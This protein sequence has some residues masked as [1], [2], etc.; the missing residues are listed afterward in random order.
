[1]RTLW[2]P[3]WPG[4]AALVVRCLA[5]ALLPLWALGCATEAPV[6][7]SLERE[8]AALRQGFAPVGARRQRPE[9]AAA[10]EG[11]LDSFLRYASR[12]N[13]R[14]QASYER[15]RAATLRTGAADKLPEPVVSY[16]LFLRRVETRVGAQRQRVGLSWTLPWPSGLEASAQA[17]SEEAQAA[18]QDFA[19]LGL[20]LE[21]R[22][23]DAYWT[24][25]ELE[26][27]RPVLEDQRAL[28]EQL[29]QAARG[30]L[31]LGRADVADLSQLE[32][33]LS[34]LSDEIL[35][36][37]AR[38]RQ[39]RA[40]LRL[41]IGAPQGTPLPALEA[42][43]VA[44]LPQPE[45]GAL[46]SQAR[47]H[48]LTQRFSLLAQAQ[49]SQARQARAASYPDLTFGVDY[50]DTAAREDVSLPDNGKDP[51]M[52]SVGVKLPL[53]GGAYDAKVHSA[54]ARGLA[55][56]HEQQAV[57]DRLEAEVVQSL[58]ELRDSHRRLHLLKN[59]LLPQ[60]QTALGSAQGQYVTQGGSV[61]TLLLAFRELD[62][63]RAWELRLRSQ[64]AMA[65]ARLEA[66]VGQP[67]AREEEP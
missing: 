38:Q 14:L 55:L 3:G 22:V 40:A 65:W 52:A 44:A 25:W 32:L 20:E 67:V 36:L 66:A 43:P 10:L 30:R 49:R 62:R 17:A 2:T 24:L 63:L 28:L 45:E 48:P 61:A 47:Q 39:A 1:M 64:H 8:A 6:A 50:I 57:A 23:C 15:W 29:A 26:R 33:S 27:M 7:G 60:A 56:E 54:Q 4:G 34:R 9:E 21:R 37:E 5:W 16:G 11:R 35:A 53:W 18:R 59:T 42:E 12:R 31:E 19:A 51:V 58:V 46:R 41:A 13:P